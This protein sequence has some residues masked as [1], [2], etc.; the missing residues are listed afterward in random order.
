MALTFGQVSSGRFLLVTWT[1]LVLQVV[2]GI[3]NMVRWT[4]FYLP[5]YIWNLSELSPIRFGKSYTLFMAA[6]HLW[7]VTA[8][9]LLIVWNIRYLRNDGAKHRNIR[10]LAA[11]SFLLGLAIAYIMMIVLLLHEGVDHAL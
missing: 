11:M 8:V 1:A 7:V 9:L 3:S 4:P 5:P 2:S 10:P 6:K